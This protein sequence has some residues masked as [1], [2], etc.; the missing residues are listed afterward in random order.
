MAKLSVGIVG[1]PNVGKSTLFNALLQKQQALSA[2]YPFATI[3]PNVG[4]VP[5]PDERLPQLAKTVQQAERLPQPPPIVPATVT[6]IDIAG[7][8][9]GA[10]EGE[11]LGNQFLAHIRETSVICHVLRDFSD[12]EIIRSG[13]TDPKSDLQTIRT[14]LL[15]AD[16]QTL[17]K[18][19]P[20]KGKI[21]LSDKLRWQAV[22]KLLHGLNQGKLAREVDLSEDEREAAAELFLLTAKPELFVINLDEARLVQASAQQYADQLDV[23]VESVIVVSAKVEAE[24]ADLPEADKQEYLA[25]LGLTSSGLER[26]IKSAYQT[27]GLMSFLTAGAKEVRAWTIAQGLTADKAAGVIHTDFEQKFIKAHVCHW[28]DFVQLGGWHEVKQAGKLRIEGR[29]YQMQP[30]DVV[31]FMIGS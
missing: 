11:G 7:L 20:P 8:V 27:L 31:E 28:Q 21:S 1:L 2:N 30:G 4:V 25:E 3:E 15:L 22:E 23:P 16:L 29:D 13:A 24:L 6:F 5:L 10:A 19:K 17:E 14:E 9:K 12:S 26:L 18:Q